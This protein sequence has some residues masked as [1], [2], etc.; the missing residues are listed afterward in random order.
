MPSNGLLPAPRI[1]ACPMAEACTGCIRTIDLLKLDAEQ[2][3]LSLD[4][5]YGRRPVTAAV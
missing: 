2:S 5:V 1:F 3:F 4:L